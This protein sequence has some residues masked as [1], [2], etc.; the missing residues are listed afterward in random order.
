MT[1]LNDNHKRRILASLQYADRLLEDNLRLV[2]PSSRQIFPQ[3]VPDVAVAEL[4]WIES[5]TDKIREQMVWLM[6]RV[7][8]KAPAPNKPSSWTLR[9]NLIVLDIALEDLYPEQMRGYGAIDPETA[10]D[11]DTDKLCH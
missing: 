1:G 6:D 2:V 11:L 3:S 10:R 7:Q 9:S 4:H 5:Y 8:A